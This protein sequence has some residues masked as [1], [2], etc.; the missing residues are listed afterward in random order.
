MS[1]VLERSYF[2]HSLAEQPEDNVS[3]FS[4]MDY[5]FGTH[6]T[7]GDMTYLNFLD[8]GIA[9]SNGWMSKGRRRKER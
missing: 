5:Q 7:F 8:C 6:P 3:K 2:L 9:R 1:Y 4:R